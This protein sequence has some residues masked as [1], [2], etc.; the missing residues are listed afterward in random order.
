MRTNCEHRA[1]SQAQ[2]LFRDRPHCEFLHSAPSVAPHHQQINT[3]ALYHRTK[4]IPHSTWFKQRVMVEI[5]NLNFLFLAEVLH[6][7]FRIQPTAV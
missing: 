3:L 6:L 2:D 5:I 4:D 1:G 7:L